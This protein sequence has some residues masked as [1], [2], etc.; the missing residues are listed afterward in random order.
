MDKAEEIVNQADQMN[1]QGVYTSKQNSVRAAALI[2]C[3]DVHELCVRMNGKTPKQYMNDM[4]EL[5]NRIRQMEL[6][7]DKMAEQLSGNAIKEWN[8]AK[9]L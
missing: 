5:K 8:R 2:L 9:N 1:P 4:A 6:V 3:V 7:G